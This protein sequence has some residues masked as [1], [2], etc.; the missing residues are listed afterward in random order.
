MAKQTLSGSKK[1]LAGEF[2]IVAREFSG[3]QCLDEHPECL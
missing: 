3:L 2:C 1:N